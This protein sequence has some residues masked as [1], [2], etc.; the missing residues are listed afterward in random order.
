MR[1]TFPSSRIRF[2]SPGFA[3][4]QNAPKVYIKVCFIDKGDTGLDDAVLYVSP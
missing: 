4:D 3:V 2:A 1:A